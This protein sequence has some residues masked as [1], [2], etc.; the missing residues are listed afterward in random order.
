[1]HQH[2]FPHVTLEAHTKAG[3]TTLNKHLINSLCFLAYL[4]KQTKCRCEGGVRTGV[5]ALNQNIYIFLFINLKSSE[6]KYKACGGLVSIKIILSASSLANSNVYTNSSLQSCL[7]D[8]AP[9][10]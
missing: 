3:E 2:V 9:D 7:K 4:Q 6:L 10:L 5:K 8:Y 1:M